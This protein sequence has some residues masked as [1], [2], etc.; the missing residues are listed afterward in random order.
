[1]RL[2][3]IMTRSVDSVNPDLP[4][5]AAF[6]RMRTKRYH[7]LVVID[8]R[9][10]LG[11]I[12]DRDL[13]GAR[14]AALRVG[15]TVGDL[16]TP[17]ACVGSPEMQVRRAANLMRSRAIGCLPVIDHGKLVGIV[18]AT[19][20]LG[21]IGQGTMKPVTESVKWTL[22]GRGPAGYHARR[23]RIVPRGSRPR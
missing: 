23:D 12:S 19:D 11:V 22:R 10:V 8:R 3:D 4:A 21:L 7:H 14:G 18:T 6:Q 9:G 5:E 16:M 15:W 20:L 13:G 2:Q 17:D 1:M